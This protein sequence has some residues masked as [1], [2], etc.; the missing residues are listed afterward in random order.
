VT[1]GPFF[2]WRQ[3][4]LADL[5]ANGVQ[6]PNWL[7]PDVRQMLQLGYIHSLV[8][9]SSAGKSYW[10]TGVA[11]LVMAAKLVVVY[12]DA[13]NGPRIIGDRL[14]GLG[15]DPAVIRRYLRYAPFPEPSEADAARVGAEIA[16]EAPALVIF[17]SGPDF[18]AAVGAASENDN[19]A[20]QRWHLLFSQ[21]IARATGAAV[22]VIEPTNERGELKRGR[23]ATAKRY[24]ADI[25]ISLQKTVRFGRDME[26]AVRLTVQKDRTGA[27]IEGVAVDYRVG[28]GAFARLPAGQG[29]AV[30]PADATHIDAVEIVA[31]VV[32]AY[33][34]QRAAKG[35]TDRISQ[36]QLIDRLPGGYSRQTVID[37]MKRAR[38]DILRPINTIDGPRNSEMYGLYE[39]P[40]PTV[41][42]TVPEHS[43][44]DNGLEPVSDRSTVPA[45]KRNGHRE[46]S[47]ETFATVP[48]RAEL[49]D[50]DAR[51]T[52]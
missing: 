1:I 30:P 45:R 4:Q 16:A 28:A 41:P 6:P 39:R 12:L 52:A 14:A 24:K 33:F 10:S 48:D 19:M 26:G 9:E 36:R 34:R 35:V 15:T 3:D 37:G 17:D 8:G 22:V 40:I 31:D 7:H 2:T 51:V 27:E 13:E 44:T 49:V 50:T 21:A 32:V 43:G 46:R 23:G 5:M 11:N 25:V 29:V 38:D 18:Y 47:P 42:G 20:I